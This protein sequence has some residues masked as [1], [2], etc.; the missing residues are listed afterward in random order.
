MRETCA[1]PRCRAVLG[2]LSRVVPLLLRKPL[3]LRGSGRHPFAIRCCRWR[4]LLGAGVKFW[5]GAVAV[6]VDRFAEQI[7]EGPFEPLRPLSLR[8]LALTSRHLAP[9]IRRC[10]SR[11]NVAV[12]GMATLS[13]TCESASSLKD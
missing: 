4:F 13:S 5:L 8:S 6:G 12:P 2:V 9:G 3:Q 11:A 7:V 1:N 10:A